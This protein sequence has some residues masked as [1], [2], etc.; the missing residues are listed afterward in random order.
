MYIT[1]KDIIGEKAIDL[2][3]PIHSGK[4]AHRASQGEVAVIAMLRDNVQYEIV[5]LI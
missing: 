5:K 3:Y 1:I 4:E 2:S